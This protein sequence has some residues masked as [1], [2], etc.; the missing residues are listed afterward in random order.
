MKFLRNSVIVT[1]IC[2][3]LAVILLAR[4]ADVPAFETAVSEPDLSQEQT[5]VS[6][7]ATS[8]NDAPAT[9]TSLPPAT[10]TPQPVPT[11]TLPPTDPPPTDTPVAARALLGL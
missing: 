7:P 1:T 5:T 8:S 6:E 11:D 10:D 4:C 3:G 2:A 9:A